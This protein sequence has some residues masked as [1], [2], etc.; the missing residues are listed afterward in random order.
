MYTRKSHSK[1]KYD[2]FEI[3]A[4]NLEQRGKQ[5]SN[6]RGIGEDQ[7]VFSLAQFVRVL[8][9]ANSTATKF[10]YAIFGLTFVS[11]ALICVQI[12]LVSQR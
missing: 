3:T 2:E 10:T 5:L 11:V 4:Q 8:G 1:L 6:A 9:R 7:I 12:S